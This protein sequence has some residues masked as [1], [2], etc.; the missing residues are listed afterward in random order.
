MS[1]MFERKECVVAFVREER[2]PRTIPPTTA[3]PEKSCRVSSSQT[4]RIK[5]L[6]SVCLSCMGGGG[7]GGG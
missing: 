7:G 3:T 2:F 6:D 4:R 5:S 1:A